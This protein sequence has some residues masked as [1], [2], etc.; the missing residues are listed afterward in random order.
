MTPEEITQAVCAYAEAELSLTFGT[1][2]PY[3][4][5][6][7]RPAS[8]YI[9]VE[10][11]TDVGNWTDSNTVSTSDDGDIAERTSSHRRATISLNTY[12][13]SADAWASQLAVA[14]RS[15]RT[16]AQALRTAGFHPESSNGPR[17]IA[18]KGDT[19]WEPRRQLTLTG[20]H[21]HTLDD[22]ASAV[23]S[24]IG[25]DLDMNDTTV[26]VSYPGDL[27]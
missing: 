5:P 12:G 15:R 4:G 10:V 11:V 1:A 14:W 9:T 27:P 19:G 2:T 13:A 7:V 18:V 22:Q 17:N 6:G 25:I 21:R 20:Y 23:V 24:S 16:A 8:A 26:S 3:Q